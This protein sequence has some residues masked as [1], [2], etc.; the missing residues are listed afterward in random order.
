MIDV[1]NRSYYEYGRPDLEDRTRA[2][3]EELSF[4][5]LIVVGHGEFG[6]PNVTS[7]FYIERV[8]HDSDEKWQ[9][10]M[11]WARDLIATAE[12]RFE[13]EITQFLEKDNHRRCTV[14]F[15][16]DG[17][18]LSVLTFNPVTKHTFCFFSTEGDHK[19]KRLS[20]ALEYAKTQLAEEF[21]WT[22]K[23]KNLA[24]EEQI[25]YFYG[26]DEDEVRLK[27]NTPEKYTNIVSITKNPI[28]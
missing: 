1:E 23:W 28:A 3:L 2:R 14:H 6:I 24:R 10:Y 13:N 16:D 12:I 8:W 22:V 4:M 26:K 18:K 27:F 9:L 17:N 7:G 15:R 19:M 25:S 11:A 20:D 21:S 5:G